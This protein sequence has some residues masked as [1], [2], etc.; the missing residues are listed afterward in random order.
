[1]KNKTWFLFSFSVSA[2]NQAFRVKIWRRLNALGAVQIKNAVYL[3][4]ADERHKEQLTWLAKEVEDEGGDALLVAGGALPLMPDE[5]VM[6]AFSR[7][8]DADYLVLEEEIR[9]CLEKEARHESEMRKFARRLEALRAI[10]FF[11]SGRGEV[12]ERLLAEASKPALAPPAPLPLLDVAEYRG[13]TW[14]T[15][16]N[17]YVDRL[18]SFWLVRRFIDP[19]ARVAFLGPEAPFTPRDGQVGFD[20]ADVAFTHVKGRITFETLA[21][22]FGALD[23]LPLRLRQVLRAIDL[24]EY[25]AGPPETMGVKQVLDGLVLAHPDDHARTERALP[26]FDALLASYTKQALGEHA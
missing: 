19:E 17:P 12:V 1:M 6:S 11:P 5:Q 16:A 3:L 25:E 21:E 9:A 15:R 22:S 18:A 4:P 14:I 24:E 20:M 2:K 8:R 7:S 10:D 13:K 26:I 23:A